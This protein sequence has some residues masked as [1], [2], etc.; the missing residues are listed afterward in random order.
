MRLAKGGMVPRYRTLVHVPLQTMGNEVAKGFVPRCVVVA[1]GWVSSVPCGLRAQSEFRDA[2]HTRRLL[3]PGA[4]HW[5]RRLAYPTAHPL[6]RKPCGAKSTRP[7]SGHQY[8]GIRC[9][10]RSAE[11]VQL[12]FDRGVDTPVSD[13]ATY[14]GRQQTSKEHTT[15]RGVIPSPHPARSYYT[16]QSAA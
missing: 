2:D 14:V 12:P 4:I 1:V 16:S 7:P 8:S 3:G 9:S 15:W 13:P 6:T 5:N 10:P 11:I